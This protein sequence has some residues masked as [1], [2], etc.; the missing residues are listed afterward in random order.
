MSA[1]DFLLIIAIAAGAFYAGYQ[2]GRASVLNPKSPSEASPL[3]GP[4]MDE[5]PRPSSVP[6]RPRGA[7]PPASA[8]EASTAPAHERAAAGRTSAPPPAA[9]GIVDKGTAEDR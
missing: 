9:A 7:P 3:P 5:A 6:P 8:G 4:R 2:I 1:F